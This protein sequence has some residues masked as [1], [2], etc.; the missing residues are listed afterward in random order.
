MQRQETFP[1][2]PLSH[3]HMTQEESHDLDIPKSLMAS[4]RSA[5]VLVLGGYWWFLVFHGGSWWFLAVLGGSWWFLVVL[6]GSW[7]F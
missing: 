7:W 3:L 1:V 2:L 6:D 4:S 5:G